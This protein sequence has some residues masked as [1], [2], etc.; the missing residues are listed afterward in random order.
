MV[1]D[2]KAAGFQHVYYLQGG[3]DS[4][5]AAGYPTESGGYKAL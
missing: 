1:N 5:L 2:M 3:F 4:W